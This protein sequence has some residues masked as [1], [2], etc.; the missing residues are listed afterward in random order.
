[1]D[2]SMRTTPEKTGFPKQKEGVGTAFSPLSKVWFTLS[3]GAVSEIY[4]PNLSTP[5][6]SRLE[7]SVSDGQGRC[8]RESLDMTHRLEH[9]DEHALTYRQVNG[10]PAGCFRLSKISFTDPSRQCFILHGRLETQQG[11]PTDYRL[12]FRWEPWT[13]GKHRHHIRLLEEGGD[14]FL[15][16]EN[17]EKAAVLAASCGMEQPVL[18]LDDGKQQ[19]VTSTVVEGSVLS[20]SLPIPADGGFQMVIG[21][22]STAEEAEKE[23]R[24]SLERPWEEIYENYRKEWQSYCKRLNSLEGWAPSLYYASLMMLKA[25]EDKEKPGAFAPGLSHPLR[26][27]AESLCQFATAF[28]GA[29]EHRSPK[30]AFRLLKGIQR[31]DGGI[32]RSFSLE[33]GSSS[34]SCPTQTAYTLLLAWQLEEVRSFRRMIVPAA[35][36]LKA[37]GNPRTIAPQEAA[38]RI[39]ALICAA[40]LAGTAG[41]AAHSTAWQETADRWKEENLPSSTAG[42]SD[43]LTWV[44]LGLSAATHPQ[45]LTAAALFDRDR[46]Q[47]TAYGPF[48]TASPL[49]ESGKNPLLSVRSVAERG[50]YELQSGRDPSS[51]LT[52]LEQAAGGEQMLSTF[53]TATG[54]KAGQS[55]DPLS[56]AEYVRLLVSQT[57]GSPCD[58]PLPAAKRY[59]NSG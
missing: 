55:P 57:W 18:L 13:G 47:E 33:E 14:R 4:H 3:Q 25:M 35:E 46:R 56:H 52:A 6:Q 34:P 1:M 20:G 7:L 15:C 40:D 41:E 44:R 37:N 26:F 39:A 58:L 28:W 5:V 29:G 11:S 42:T 48:W 17:G 27:S 53:L 30:Q 2:T 54:E 43:W 10:D 50:H 45:I 36:F 16:A 31:K 24:E 9:P 21:F 32:P 59:S 23:V 19:P 8:Y 49:N 51:Y 12:N 22:G 38:V